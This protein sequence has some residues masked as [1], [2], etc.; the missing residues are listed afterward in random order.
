MAGL[1]Q[2]HERLASGAYANAAEVRRALEAPD[3]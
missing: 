1:F 3:C 2:T